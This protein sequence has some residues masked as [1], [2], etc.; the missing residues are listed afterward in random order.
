MSIVDTF[1][2]FDIETTG[3]DTKKSQIIEI[4]AYKFDAAGHEIGRFST[5]VNPGVPIPKLLRGKIPISD[6]MVKYGPSPKAAVAAFKAFVG[7]AMFVG[8]NS[9]FDLNFIA[10]QDP[11]FA[12]R[13]MLDTMSLAKALL[14]GRKGYT[15]T[16][17]VTDQGLERFHA[18]PHRAWSDAYVTAKLLINLV[19]IAEKLPKAELDQLRATKAESAVWVT[20]FDELLPARRAAGTAQKS[21]AEPNQVVPIESPGKTKDSD[22]SVSMSNERF[23]AWL[24]RQSNS[25][26]IDVASR[27]QRVSIGIL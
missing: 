5:L 22:P 16:G 25:R 21:A 18:R 26:R 12:G 4:A 8:H 6:A 9:D 10:Q 15:L 14:P 13:A 19:E 23:V 20:F 17:L 11:S 1:V 2:A 3:L 24:S 27:V 7:D